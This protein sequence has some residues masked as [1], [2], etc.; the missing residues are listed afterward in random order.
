MRAIFISWFLVCSLIASAQASE[1]VVAETRQ[2]WTLKVDGEPF[3]IQGAG[4]GLRRGSRGEDYLGMA[5]ALGANCVRTWGTDQGDAAYLDAAWK[6]GLRVDA[7]IWIDSADPAYGVSYLEKNE[8]IEKRRNEAL[9][10]VKRF[11]DHPAIL[12]WN[13]GNEAFFFTKSEEERIA[14]GRFLE[15]LIQQIHLLDP[16]HPVVYSSSD[17]LELPYLKKY[18]PSLDIVGANVYGSVRSLHSH[19]EALGFDKPYLITEFGPP[20]PSYSAKDANGR[21]AE[22]E[23]YQKAIVYKSLWEQI[24]EHKDDNLGGF[25]FHLGETTQET[26][27][28][29]NINEKT[30]P[31]Q[32]FWAIYRAYTGKTPPSSA[33]KMRKL[34]LSQVT[35]LKP[36]QTIRVQVF[37][38]EAAPN[39]Y[40]YEYRVSTAKEGIL[41]YY[42][43]ETLDTQIIGSGPE[44]QLRVPDKEGM[45]RVYCFV[46]D[47]AGNVSSLNRTIQVRSN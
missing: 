26:M 46:K 9:A 18:V 25:V 34:S 15:N 1:V 20:L 14:L 4:C 44:V 45:Y 39:D 40:I 2:G 38:K 19:W 43:N 36:G 10:Y 11:K 7:G 28:W 35:H 29:W 23:D 47:K 6:Y 42:V 5:K 13:V 33:P 16:H 3:Y 41:K 22:L 30:G 24:V 27:T 37:L 12:L 21:P 8:H 31:R 17:S 32:S